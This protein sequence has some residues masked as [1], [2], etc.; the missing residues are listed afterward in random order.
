MNDEGFRM[1]DVD[2]Q[3]MKG[4]SRRSERKNRSALA[5]AAFLGLGLAMV[6]A[7]VACEDSS[8]L[9]VI[10]GQIAPQP[11]AQGVGC[12][13]LPGASVILQLGATLDVAIR[14]NYQAI[15]NVQNQLVPRQD[16][17]NV[18][19]ETNRIRVNGAT[20]DLTDGTQGP[21]ASFRGLTTQTVVDPQGFAAVPVNLIDPAT[22]ARLR[23]QIPVGRTLEV[24]AKVKMFG[25]TLGN[26]SVESA[27]FQQVITVCNKC[28]AFF[29]PEATDPQFVTPQAPRNC[30]SLIEPKG[31]APCLVGQD[32]PVDCRFCRGN[33]GCA[34]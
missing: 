32:G 11:A 24:I 9:F 6:S 34:P 14:D 1:N 3:T 2:A 31:A 17:A 30:A 8:Q 7:G 5:R 4:V 16:N 20:V 23:S 21:I 29:P 28:L 25:E 19:A 33:A 27:E 15:Y 26:T 22:A 10:R 18:R 13:Y 12:T